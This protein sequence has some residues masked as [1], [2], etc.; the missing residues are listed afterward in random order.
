MKHLAFF[1]NRLTTEQSQAFHMA[2]DDLVSVK[3]KGTR[4]KCNEGCIWITWPDR[5]ETVLNH[6]QSVMISTRGRICIWAFKDASVI[7]SGGRV[8]WKTCGR[9]ILSKNINDQNIIH[10]SLIKSCLLFLT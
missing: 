4:I 3:G 8:K 2:P 9:Y 1:K 10:T 6:G 7:I 5:E